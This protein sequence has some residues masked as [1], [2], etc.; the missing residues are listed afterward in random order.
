MIKPETQN[1]LIEI[2]RELA[3]LAKKIP[4]EGMEFTIPDTVM[5]KNPLWNRTT[6][7]IHSA[8]SRRFC[9]NLK[10]GGVSYSD[11][12]G[13]SYESQP[14]TPFEIE[15]DGRRYAV[16]WLNGGEKPLAFSLKVI[17]ER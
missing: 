9:D 13:L 4:S 12:Q 6:S 11:K 7:G 1:V 16:A 15:L 5:G 14:K 17:A 2:Y 10:L 8:A 3:N